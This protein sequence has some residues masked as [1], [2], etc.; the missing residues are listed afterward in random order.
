M[1]RILLG[2]PSHSVL[3]LE[4]TWPFTVHTP[5]FRYKVYFQNKTLPE[6]EWYAGSLGYRKLMIFAFAPWKSLLFHSEC[7]MLHD[8]GL[9][10]AFVAKSGGGPHCATSGSRT[11]SIGPMVAR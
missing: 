6:A 9:A 1:T 10:I 4:F 2:I 8:G 5:Y 7:L 3:L 11:S